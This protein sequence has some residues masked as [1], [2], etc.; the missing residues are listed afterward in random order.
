[1]IKEPREAG[2]YSLRSHDCL[3]AMEHPANVIL[4]D[5]CAPFVDF[6][7]LLHAILPEATAAGWDEKEVEAALGHIV[8]ELRPAIH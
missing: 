5:S 4:R 6:S 3:K 8:R 2:E 1:M 7:S